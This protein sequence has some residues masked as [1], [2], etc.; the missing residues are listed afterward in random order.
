MCTEYVNELVD[1]ITTARSMYQ[2]SY[3]LLGGDFN[4]PHIDWETSSVNGH[5]I[6]RRVNEEFINMQNDLALEQMVLF[7]TRGQNILDLLFTSHPAIF[8]DKCKTLPAFG[9]IDHETVLIDLSLIGD[10]QQSTPRK[11]LLWNKAD[12]SIIC[13]HIKEMTSLVN[14][15]PQST[16]FGNTLKRL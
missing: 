10:Q 13:S 2:S 3:F 5:Q 12:Q 16:V 7:P 6:P 8:I 15:T 1:D 11:I 4:L 9:K 14:N